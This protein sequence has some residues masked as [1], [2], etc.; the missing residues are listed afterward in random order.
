M[1]WL[2]GFSRPLE[3]EVL[4]VERPGLTD[5]R[6]GERLY[7]GRGDVFF[8]LVD[9][10]RPR[11]RDGNL[12]KCED[13]PKRRLRH[14]PVRARQEREVLR[15]HRPTR[16]HRRGPLM[17][18]V[19]GRKGRPG[20]NRTREESV[21]QRFPRD[22]SDP[23]PSGLRKDLVDPLLTEQ[24]EWNL[25]DLGLAG[26]KAEDG[27]DRLMDRNAV[28]VDLVFPLQRLQDLV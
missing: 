18:D 4:C 16:N 17:T 15:R 6:F 19:S 10:L 28:V 1:G 20:T 11:D 3:T 25:E 5:F 22:D 23:C 12:G 27:F 2:K 14:R 24:A 7:R 21:P 13:E 9:R 26:L 8:D